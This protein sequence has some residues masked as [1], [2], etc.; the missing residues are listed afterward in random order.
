[1]LIN[2]IGE[3]GTRARTEGQSEHERLESGEQ[4][5]IDGRPVGR[6]TSSNG[7]CSILRMAYPL[8]GETPLVDEKSTLWPKQET[9][10]NI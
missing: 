2:E 7:L 4:N 1:M 3:C 5:D 8:G 6:A 10:L 9:T